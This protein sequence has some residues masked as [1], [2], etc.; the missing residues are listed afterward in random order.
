MEQEKKNIAQLDYI[1]K[2]KSGWIQLS[3]ESHLLWEENLRIG[4]GGEI[5]V[6]C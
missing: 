1:K 3:V 5:F 4:R 6:V 2:D